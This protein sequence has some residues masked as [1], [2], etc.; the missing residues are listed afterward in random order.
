MV[1]GRLCFSAY[2]IFDRKTTDN[3]MKKILLLFAVAILHSPVMF[4]QQQLSDTEKLSSLAKLYGFLKY[5]HP[6]V[7]NGQYNWD[8]E[9][10]K[11]LPKVLQTTD[12]ESLS[13][14]YL[15]WIASL[16][17]LPPCKKCKKKAVYFDKNFDLSWT[18]NS[19]LFSDELQSKLQFIEQ[20]RNLSENHYVGFGPVKNIKVTNEPEWTL[21]DYPEE[22]YRLLG[23]IK[24]WN[25]VEYFYPYKYLAD[26]DWN[27]VLIEM[28][29]RFRQ[30][31][32]KEDYQLLIK[33]LVAKLDDTHA[34][35]QFSEKPIKFLPIMLSHLDGKAVITGFYQPELAQKNGF[36]LGDV[37]V[38]I[39]GISMQKLVEENY[40]YLSGSHTNIKMKRLYSRLLNTSEDK[41]VLHVLRNGQEIEIVGKGYDF[42]SFNFWNNP[43]D[44]KYKM[45]ED[46]IGYISLKRL[47]G[48]EIMAAFKAFKDSKAVILDLRTYPNISYKML[49]KYLNSEKRIFAEIYRPDL[50]YPGR[51]IYKEPMNTEKSNKIFKGKVILLVSDE[52]FS[53]SEYFAMAIQ[54]GD[55]VITVGNQ[56]AG[57]D[58]DVVIF[59]YLGAYK[60]A[61]SGLG[62]LYPDGSETQ[63]KGVRIDVN[64]TPTI[65][66]LQ[67][68]RDEI[69]EKAIEIAK[70]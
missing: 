48:K 10:L 51:F 9:M 43:K 25:I 35:I 3:R 40:K 21:P 32:S 41:V 36:K 47:G 61:F 64:V 11:Y 56:T 39:N 26:T 27:S 28:I 67:A 46:D 29:P 15:S 66:G 1:I 20:N 13:Q 7:A 38:K 37:I 23:L 69:L 34:W 31:G 44:I 16:G 2:S 19:V 57:A 18:Q 65:E 50:S 6:N 17:E 53:R 70:Q 24:Y 33:E 8:E 49:T 62:I 63:R 30:V 68:G 55:N 54:P 4:G 5:Y 58:G 14:L 22:A 52:S 12:K 42:K 45:L 59:E 60:T